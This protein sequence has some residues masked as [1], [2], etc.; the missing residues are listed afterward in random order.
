[1]FHIRYNSIKVWNNIFGWTL[2]VIRIWRKTEWKSTAQLL[3]S[4][5]TNSLWISLISVPFSL[6]LRLSLSP[7]TLSS[8]HSSLASFPSA[9]SVSIIK[10]SLSAVLCDDTGGD[11]QTT[12]SAPEEGGCEDLDWEEEREMERLACEGDDFIPPK[13][14]VCNFI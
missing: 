4:M 1:M 6:Y 14:I 3:Q 8:S 9:F 12:S 5:K 13:I 2:Y 10:L 7:S 11:L